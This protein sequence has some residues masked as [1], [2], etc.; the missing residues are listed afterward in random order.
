[1]EKINIPLEELL[2]AS[3]GSIYE[4][5]ILATKRAINLTDGEKCLLE[6]PGEKALDNALREIGS[7]KIRVK[8]KK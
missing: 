8:R 7:G 2:K 3:D 6:K 1:M 4:V 5:A